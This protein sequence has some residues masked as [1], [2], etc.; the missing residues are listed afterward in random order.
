MK[1]LY[2]ALACLISVS[3]YEQQVDEYAEANYDCDG[4][5]IL[6]LDKDGVCKS[7]EE[8][9]YVVVDCECEFFDP[10]T[11]TVFF[12]NVDEE[13]CI[14]IEDCYCECINDSDGDGIC[15]ENELNGCISSTACNYNPYATED[16]DSCV[17]VGD[18]CD[19]GDP[20]T[21]DDEM[22]EDCECAGTSY[23]AVDELEAFSVLI[24]PTK[25]KKIEKVIDA[26]GK[27]VNHTT[28]QLLFYIYDDGSV[29]K[30]FI[31]Y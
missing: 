4:N 1:L 15:D 11:Y 12:T 7:C 19:D 23:S 8:Y 26:F 10:V 6:Y 31:V 24:Y 29:E 28:N 14:I 18:P 20:N 17:F 21:L 27:E 3:L 22:Q 30:K 9:T 25:D 16:D 13:N 5:C 2:T